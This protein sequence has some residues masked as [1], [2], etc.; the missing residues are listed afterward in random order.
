MMKLTRRTLIAMA[1]LGLPALAQAAEDGLFGELLSGAKDAA[2]RKFLE[3]REGESRWDGK[4][5]YDEYDNKRY[6]RDEWRRELERRYREETSGRDWRDSKR[7]SWEEKRRKNRKDRRDDR[8][9]RRHDDRRDRRDDRS[10]R[11]DRRRDDRRDDRRRDDR[12]DRRDDRRD[13][14]DRRRDDRRERRDD[15]KQDL[16]DRIVDRLKGDGK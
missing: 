8:D 3:D 12:R 14:D 1:A 2:Y 13:R 5:Y 15:A 16:R 11:D 7:R 6:T 9:D 10:D 4:Y